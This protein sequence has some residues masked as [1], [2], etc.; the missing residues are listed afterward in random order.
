M[1]EPKRWVQS[2]VQRRSTLRMKSRLSR[3]VLLALI[4]DHADLVGGAFAEYQPEGSFFRSHVGKDRLGDGL[5]RRAA[6]GG[7]RLAGPRHDGGSEESLT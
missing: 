4:E 3:I 7:P 1:A 6:S 2:A 5:R